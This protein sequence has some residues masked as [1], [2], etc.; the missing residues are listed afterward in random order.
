MGIAGTGI[1]PLLFFLS[2]HIGAP[3]GEV[4]AEARDDSLNA[5]GAGGVR[6]G[7]LAQR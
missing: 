1:T 7:Q 4:G 6:W 2:M 5:V 3:V